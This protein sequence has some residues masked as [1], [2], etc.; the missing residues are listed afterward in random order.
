MLASEIAY[1]LSW[2][3]RLLKYGRVNRAL[4]GIVIDTERLSD[5]SRRNVRPTDTVRSAM[6]KKLRAFNVTAGLL[7]FVN[8]TATS[9]V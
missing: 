1:R 6:P 7:W 4:D 9:T 8:R 2:S 3:A 5:S